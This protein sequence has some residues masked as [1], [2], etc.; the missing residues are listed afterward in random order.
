VRYGRQ[1]WQ[2]LSA[3]VDRGSTVAEVARRYGVQPRTLSW[4]RW[5]LKKVGASRPL[6]L[7][8]VVRSPRTAAAPSSPIEIQIS[9]LIIRVQAETDV[10][11]LT[12]LIVALRLGC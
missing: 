1:F 7:P 9:D 2:Q 11:Y 12:R 5:R 8:V 4:W 6:L 10:E 3:E